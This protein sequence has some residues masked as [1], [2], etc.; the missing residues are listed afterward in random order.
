MGLG[1]LQL[2][3]NSK[4][5]LQPPTKPAW[6]QKVTEEHCLA[7]A[8]LPSG[9][10]SPSAVKWLLHFCH[11]FSSLNRSNSALNI[12]YLHNNP[13]PVSPYP[14]FGLEVQDCCLTHSC[15]ENSSCCSSPV[16]G[17]RNCPFGEPR[18]PTSPLETCSHNA[19]MIIQTAQV[20]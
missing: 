17:V 7:K 15:A 5:G 10:H 9:A 20:S 8:L 3:C 6:W 16:R 4:G 12:T 11:S 14:A 2:F 19:G 1:L 18:K 13:D